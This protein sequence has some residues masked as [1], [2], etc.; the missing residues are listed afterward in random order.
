[1]EAGQKYR[2]HGKKKE[3]SQPERG[4]KLD[5]EMSELIE[6]SADGCAKGTRD[7]EKIG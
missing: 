7:G 5:L 4:E 6:R 3:S 1:M 2:L